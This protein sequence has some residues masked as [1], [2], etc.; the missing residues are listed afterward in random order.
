MD[1]RVVFLVAVLVSLWVGAMTRAEAKHSIVFVS[2]EFLYDSATTLPEFSEWL[3]VNHPFSCTVL[4][5]DK[6]NNVPGLEVL[7][8]TDL[9][10]LFVRRMTLP[11]EQINIVRDYVESGRP[12][13]GIR[14]TSHAFE[15]WPKFDANV[16]GGNYHGHHPNALKGTAKT[17]PG[18]IEHPILRGVSPEFTMGGSLYM[19]QPIDKNATMLLTGRV[20][21]H[22]TEPL[23]WTH[24]YGKSRV[25]YT[26]LG[27]PDDFSNTAFRRLLVN[28]IYWALKLKRPA[29]AQEIAG[30]YGI[31]EGVS[32]RVGVNLF[33][34][35][36][37][38]EICVVLDVRTAA[39]YRNGHIPGAVWIDW[40][41][42]G[43][44]A[45]VEKLDREKIYLVHCAGGVRSARACKQMSP[46][47]FKWLVDLAP[48]FR[49]WEKKD[50]PVER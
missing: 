35:L 27:H 16:L 31:E 13:I 41:S 7:K 5:R 49:D 15:N 43:F 38:E 42:P 3:A 25:F 17:T 44:T 39:E 40:F 24:N 26:S 12:L 29:D 28:S 48:G 47:G 22:P 46:M 11:D 32:S 45:K 30:K 10:I 19:N 2:G 21:G 4:K 34:K 14:T 23:A 36:W 8:G 50:M 1:K 18:G 6:E 33:G 37:K 20:K 9:V